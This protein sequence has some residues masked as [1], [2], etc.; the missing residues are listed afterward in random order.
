[1]DPLPL[2]IQQM[3]VPT[4]YDHRVEAPI[5]LLRAHISFVVL[6]GDYVYKVKKPVNLGF[7]DFSS[8]E[9]R[10]HFCN[11]E[12]RLNRR[13]S[14]EIYLE[15][16]SMGWAGD[17]FYLHAPDPLEYAVKM[18][19]FPQSQLFSQLF[20][21]NQLGRADLAALA[22]QVAA[23][24]QTALSTPDIQSFGERKTVQIIHENNYRLSEAFIGKFKSIFVDDSTPN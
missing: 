14:P 6:T 10:H 4:F 9:Q 19:Q 3:L 12:L 16:V 21:S 24:H 22:K 11:E 17:R 5:Q 20:Q 23:F 2:L 13:I 15:V 8:L 18:R 7:L 1:M